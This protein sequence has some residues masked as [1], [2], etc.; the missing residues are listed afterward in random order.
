M[1]AVYTWTAS[2]SA[3]GTYSTS[4]AAPSPEVVLDLDVF[5]GVDARIPGRRPDDV[6]LGGCDVRQVRDGVLDRALDHAAER[7]AGA[8]ERHRHRHLAVLVLNAVDQAEVD[9]AFSQL[10]VLHRRQ[11]L[12][13]LL[14][15]CHSRFA[16]ELV[17]LY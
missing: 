15:G 5:A 11:P 16:P 2:E 1:E 3:G 17:T 12:H 6:D 13:N 9:D 8:G 14:F 10:R 4:Q 7:A